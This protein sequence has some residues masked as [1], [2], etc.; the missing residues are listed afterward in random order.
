MDPYATVDELRAERAQLVRRIESLHDRAA[1]APLKGDLA[2]EWNRTNTELDQL[3]GAIKQEQV[4]ENR[5][6]EIADAGGGGVPATSFPTPEGGA[7]RDRTLRM[8][9]SRHRT[10]G[11]PDD[12]AEQLSDLVRSEDPSGMFARQLQA[13]ANPLYES[14]FRKALTYGN[15]AP[16][17]MNAEELQAR[18]DMEVLER[19]VGLGSGVTLPFALDPS[20]QLTSDG[21]VSPIRRIARTVRV[22]T[23]EWRGV[24]GVGGSA[25]YDA[26]S[27]EVSDDSPTLAQP[28]I[29]T[30]RVQYFVP[31][32]IEIDQDW[33][34]LRNELGKLLLD[35]R[36]VLEATKM[37]SGTGVVEPQGLLVGATAVVTGAATAPTAAN[38]YSTI[39]ALPPR[40]R[41]NATW[42]MGLT[43]MN[44]LRQLESGNGARLFPE[45][46]AGRLLGKPVEEWST[47]AG[48]TASGATI[49]TV[50]DFSKYVIVDRV[51]VQAEIIP[52]LFGTVANFPT[53]QRGFYA[54]WRN[55]G[56]VIAMQAFR[57]EKNA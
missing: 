27:Q 57:S 54:L 18:S 21:S 7:A 1:G 20:I 10:D 15:S 33:T 5:L 16:L 30:R 35:A 37:L 46:D 56:S 42:V 26:E 4:R 52:H 36:D 38:V 29:D 32:S 24:T 25:S 45:L 48:G 31:F 6:R 22:N 49:L 23:N 28:V 44:K 13:Q 19:A 50:G 14:W 51:G 41:P 11:L 34:E 39:E 55:S 53:G 40:F 8:L 47:Y 12:A 43:A 17:H 3:D 9:E 2:A